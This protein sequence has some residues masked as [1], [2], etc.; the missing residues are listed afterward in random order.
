[1][2]EVYV[3]ICDF[4]KACRNEFLAVQK[5]R[6]Y[7]AAADMSSLRATMPASLHRP[8]SSAPVKRLVSSA[9]HLKLA[10]SPSFI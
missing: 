1:M 5:W 6:S 4:V 9:K 8:A 2:N 10:S 7:T 3:S